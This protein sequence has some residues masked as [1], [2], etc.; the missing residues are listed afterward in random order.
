MTLKKS[1]L[2]H[3]LLSCFLAA[4]ATTGSIFSS[5]TY[6]VEHFD[7]TNLCGWATHDS[8]PVQI[9]PI[10]RATRT[11]VSFAKTIANAATA[12]TASVG[13]SVEQ[14]T[15]PLAMVRPQVNETIKSISTIKDWLS[16]PIQKPSIVTEADTVADEV[17]EEI[18]DVTP[19]IV[20]HVPVVDFDNKIEA[21]EPWATDLAGATPPVS[22]PNA[23]TIAADEA[24]FAVDDHCS[25]ENLN[26]EAIDELVEELA[27][28][29]PIDLAEDLADDIN[30]HN[31]VFGESVLMPVESNQIEKIAVDKDEV[32]PSNDMIVEHR[33]FVGSAPIIFSIDEAYMPY[34][35][36]VRDLQTDWWSPLAKRPFCIRA[37][38]ELPDFELPVD[39]D[40]ISLV[41]EPIDLPDAETEI[42]SSADCLMEELVWQATL[43]LEKGSEVRNWFRPDNV[44]H[45]FA[46]LVV[47]SNQ[48]VSRLTDRLA[49]A[50]PKVKDLSPSESGAKLLARA[51]A[52][53][54]S[55]QAETSEFDQAE[56]LAK[57]TATL[58]E[59]VVVVQ[60]IASSLSDEILRVASAP[61]SAVN[62]P[63][64]HR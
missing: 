35:L 63:S 20:S 17:V 36:A 37:R 52:I 33:T 42:A 45:K 57:A 7:E 27:T 10:A 21:S 15:E 60:D 13:L 8:C 11:S 32:A 48:V 14:M 51:K 34:D 30:S 25:F 16:L 59:L 22:I 58:K 41:G 26:D 47:T 39:Q 43:A 23:E 46:S 50:W 28:D 9:S 61:S 29:E 44:G 19:E 40:P 5:N 12:A 54:Q 53:E 56:T 49:Q 3:W 1:R 24:D 31:D 62:T 4:T 38:R 6:A 18:G 2:R 64:K 55:N